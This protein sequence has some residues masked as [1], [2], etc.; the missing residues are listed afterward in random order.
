MQVTPH[1]V[2]D[3]LVEF[4]NAEKAR[5]DKRIDAT[6]HGSTSYF[7]AIAEWTVLDRVLNVHK[8]KNCLW[9]MSELER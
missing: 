5:L 2:D 1:K 8:R 3:N 6:K 4:I 7:V 9:N